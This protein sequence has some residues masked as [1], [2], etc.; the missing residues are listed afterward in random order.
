MKVKKR[1]TVNDSKKQA[2]FS[3]LYIVATPIGHLKDIT[4]HALE[5]LKNVDLILAEDTRHSIHLLKHYAIQKP[6]KSLNEHNEGQKISFILSLIQQGQSIA[7]ISDAGTPLI[8]D[9]GYALVKAA[10]GVGI[11]VIPIPGPTALVAALSVSGLPTDRFLFEGF[12]PARSSAR[13]EKLSALK[14]ESGTLIFFETPHRILSSLEDMIWC[15]G[16]SRL[17]VIARE[18]TKQ[19]ETIDRDTL[20]SLLKKLKMNPE[21]QQGE[22]VILIAGA[23]EAPSLNSEEIHLLTVLLKNF[24]LKQTVK[25]ASEIT[26]KNKNVLYKKALALLK[27]T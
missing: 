17:G 18:L 11:R 14:K 10:H 3:A 21:K 9:P 8:S 24:P 15:W 27:A 1:I 7:L 13:R 20:S 2:L 6:L 23:T 12:L 16:E 22:F 5:V 25:L 19:F 4:L 26:Q